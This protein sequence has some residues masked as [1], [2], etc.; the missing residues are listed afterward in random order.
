MKFYILCEWEI[1]KLFGLIGKN[2]KKNWLLNGSECRSNGMVTQLPSGVWP[3]VKNKRSAQGAED[4]RRW[5][6]ADGVSGED[7][8]PVEKDLP[9]H[10]HFWHWA[11]VDCW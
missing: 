1:S 7:G 8:T 11:I 3:R 2:A 4:E 9:R 10:W 6:A 5:A